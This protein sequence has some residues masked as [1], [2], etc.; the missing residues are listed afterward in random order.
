MNLNT[1]YYTV[2]AAYS[3]DCINCSSTC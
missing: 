2:T 1:V 3:A